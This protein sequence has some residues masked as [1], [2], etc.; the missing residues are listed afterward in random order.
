MKPINENSIEESA[1]EILQSLGWEYVHGLSIAPGAEFS[2]RES[3]EQIILTERLRKAV[4]L[5][6]PDI[7]QSAREQA[8]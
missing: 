6:N 2:E 1:I 3:F 7:P 8:I 5:L 4:A